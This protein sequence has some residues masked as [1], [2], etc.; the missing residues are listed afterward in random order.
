MGPGH[1]GA[2]F[3]AA[4]AGPG[5]LDTG[6]AH[7]PA[8][9]LVGAPNQL[10]PPASLQEGEAYI[11]DANAAGTVINALPRMTLVSGGPQPGTGDHFGAAISGAGTFTGGGPDFVAVGVPNGGNGGRVEIFTAGGVFSVSIPNPTLLV[12]ETFGSALAEVDLGGSTTDGFLVGNP[13]FFD[14]INTPGRAYIFRN[15]NAS[16]LV[17]IPFSDTEPPPV[18]S[19][20]TPS[21]SFGQVVAH[22]PNTLSSLLG[23][24]MIAA[25]SRDVQDSFGYRSMS[26]RIHVNLGRVYM[27][28]YRFQM[29]LP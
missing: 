10:Q 23:R 18:S 25:P 6:L 16:G 13:Q 14:G 11:F 19:E 15:P 7:P 12:G 17:T 1:T 27:F 20:V 8:E 3:G 5:N 22:S 21:P 4:L 29:F 2:T 28:G 26:P 24:S 9:I